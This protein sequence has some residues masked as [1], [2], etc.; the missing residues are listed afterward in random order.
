MCNPTCSACIEWTRV[1]QGRRATDGAWV[2]VCPK[3]AKITRED[4]Q[5]CGLFMP[6]PGVSAGAVG[7]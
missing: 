4:A 3:A 2:K 1:Y 6:A 5:P 7:K